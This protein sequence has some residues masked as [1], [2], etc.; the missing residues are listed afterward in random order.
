MIVAKTPLMMD[1]VNVSLSLGHPYDKLS[2]QLDAYQDE[3][4]KRLYELKALTQQKLV[5]RFIIR[6]LPR[7]RTPQVYDAF[8]AAYRVAI[9][10]KEKV[11]TDI[12]MLEKFEK[13]DELLFDKWIGGDVIPT[14]N[15]E[16]VIDEEYRKYMLSN[17]LLP[18]DNEQVKIVPSKTNKK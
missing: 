1:A 9:R 6:S 17:S 5:Y 8:V 12:K 13:Q 18:V 16:P 11:E 4:M 3:F 10:E 7:A 14:T 2:P 15:M